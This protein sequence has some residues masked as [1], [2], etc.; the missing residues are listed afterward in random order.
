MAVGYEQSG[1]TQRVRFLCGVSH[2]GREYGPDYPDK[3][4]DLDARSAAIYV[5]EGRAQYVGN[6]TPP[7]KA[8]ASDTASQLSRLRK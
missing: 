8:P 1:G 5:R 3:E 7:A 6:D 4:C 2:E